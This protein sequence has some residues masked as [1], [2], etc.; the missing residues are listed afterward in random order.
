VKSDLT[1]SRFRATVTNHL[2]PPSQQL[3]NH[4]D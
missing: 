4:P 1:N 3:S 2:N